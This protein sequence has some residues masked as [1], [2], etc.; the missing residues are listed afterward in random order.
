MDFSGTT[1]LCLGDRMLDRFAYCGIDRI[2]PEAPVPVLLLERV[3]RMLGGAG[4]VARNIAALGGRA[5]LM[6]LL[7]TDA[8]GEEVRAAIRATPHLV[9]AHVISPDRATICKTRYI[10][11][12]Q[13]IMRVDEEHAHALE[14]DE[15]KQLLAAIAKTLPDVDAVILSDY[16]KCVLGRKIVKHAIAQARSRQI[17]VF[18]DP[19]SENFRHYRGASCITPNLAELA[20]ASRMPVASDPEVIAAATRVMRDAKA[21]AI[22]VTRSDK[23]MMLIEASGEVHIEAARAREVFDVSGAG[24]TVIAVLALTHASGQKLP[25]AMRLANTAAGIVV[26][27]LGTATVEL[28]ELTLELSREARN[29]AA[30]L[31]K[32]YSVAEAETLVRQWKSRGLSVGFTNGCFDIV[33]PGHV[34]YLAG[35]RAECDRLIVA[36]NSDASTRRLKGPS[37]PVNSLEDRLAVIAALASVDAVISFD[38]DTPLELIRRL[39]PDVLMKGADYTIETVVGAEDVIAMGGRVAL[40][41]LLEGHS[42]TK[43]IGRLR[44]PVV[45]LTGKG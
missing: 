44:A 12:H 10:A 34:G 30:H 18:I 14:A 1:V 13:Q 8:A 38:E 35:A 36:L 39:R 3:E 31:E 40:I 22:L 11:A 41:N 45:A 25:E 4:N 7:G 19:K 33:H 43:V 23:G 37:R 27:K 28:D 16:G 2:S 6:G 17:P 32:I 5:V 42:T 24:D 9:D 15:E 20:R 26:S 29:Q 21:E